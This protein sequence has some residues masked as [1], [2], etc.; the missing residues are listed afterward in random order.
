[1]SLSAAD[2]RRRIDEWIWV[3]DDARTVEADE[4]LLIAYPD[5]FSDPTIALRWRS[6]DASTVDDV[7]EAARSLGRSSP[8][9]FFNL[10]ETTAE[11]EGALVARGA[12]LNMTLAV[13]ALDLASLPAIPVPADV[14]VRPPSEIDDVLAQA[15]LDHEVFGGQERSEASVRAEYD[16]KGPDPRAVLAWRAGE[17]VGFAGSSIAEDTLRLY[18]GGV[19]EAAR[20]TGVYRAL[21][22]HRLAVGAAAG[23]RVAVVKGRL[24]TS[25]P[26]LLRSGFERFG[27]VRA[28]R[29]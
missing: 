15:R 6:P 14:D 16:A 10:D 29:L 22:A 4:F 9:T 11:L 1:V 26:T 13:L 24:D 21:L 5:W 28:Y 8:V 23:A 17:P 20:G 25:A 2:V 18:G 7:L 27:E 3:P 19:A 12:E